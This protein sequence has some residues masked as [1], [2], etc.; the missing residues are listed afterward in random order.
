MGC[1]TG[2]YTL[3]SE[4]PTGEAVMEILK[5]M[6]QWIAEL[7]DDFQIPGATAAECGNY[8]DHS[9]TEAK[10]DARKFSEIIGNQIHLGTYIYL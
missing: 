9:L 8:C 10:E 1:R 4:E 5:K 2:M 7:P 3:F 6:Y